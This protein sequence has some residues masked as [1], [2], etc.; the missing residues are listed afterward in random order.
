[1]YLEKA[2]T[3]ELAWFPVFCA[4]YPDFPWRN[5]EAVKNVNSPKPI[6]F[7]HSVSALLSHWPFYIND[8]SL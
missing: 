3:F 5:G 8:I 2:H 4:N 1:M 7:K 6:I